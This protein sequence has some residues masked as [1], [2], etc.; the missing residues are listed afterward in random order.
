M[1]KVDQLHLHALEEQWRE[2]STLN[3]VDIQCI[4]VAWQATWGQKVKVTQLSVLL[5]GRYTA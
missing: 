4:E 5:A 3:L 2:L 1:G